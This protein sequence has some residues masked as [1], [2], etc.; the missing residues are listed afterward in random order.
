LSGEIQKHY[1]DLLLARRPQELVQLSSNWTPWGEQAAD[2]AV[3]NGD[4]ALVHAVVTARGRTRTPVWPKAYSALVGLY[5]AEPAP[6]V[7]GDFLGALGDNTIGERLGKPI[8]RKAQLAGDIWFY[9]GARYGEYL[10]ATKQE[11]PEGFLPAALEQS[12]ASS[13]AYLALADYY[14]E[15]GDFR[16]AIGDYNHTL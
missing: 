6:G 2:Y 1:F 12:P 14:A 5:F 4:P 15:S 9:Y 3:A 13:D 8:D 11:G 10:S 7:N 16:A